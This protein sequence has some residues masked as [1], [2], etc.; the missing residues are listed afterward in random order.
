[1]WNDLDVLLNILNQHLQKDDLSDSLEKLED[2]CRLPGQSITE[3]LAVFDSKYKKIEK[4]K[5]LFHLK[6]WPSNYFA[7]L[8]SPKKRNYWS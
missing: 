2:L 4:K 8:I 6:F 7:K 5:I 1:M 3:Y